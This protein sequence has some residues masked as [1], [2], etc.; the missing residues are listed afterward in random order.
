MKR[1]FDIFLSLFGLALLS[2]LFVLISCLIKRED[3]GPVIYGSH[4]V[5]R[6]HQM[7]K[8]F[9]FR[10]MVVNAD[11]IGARST[12][13]GDSRITKV[14]TWLRKTKFDELPQLLNVLKGDMSFVGPR[15][16][17]KH[18]VD[19]FTSDEKRILSVRPG[20]TDWASIVFSDEGAILK[21]A[22]DADQAYMEQIRPTKLLL[23]KKYV[24]K[25]N[26]FVD[27]K[28]LYYTFRAVVFKKSLDANAL[29]RS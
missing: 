9:K 25:N 7:F 22:A 10:S 27:L 23:Q 21:G 12:S 13:D 1:L 11:K 3:G 5:G 8:L 14:G 2:P 16:E 24:D 19:M 15:P 28:I 18:F 26:F 6:K 20:I 29:L 17:V 4:R